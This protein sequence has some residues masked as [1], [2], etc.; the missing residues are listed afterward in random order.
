MIK[1]ILLTNEVYKMSIKLFAEND[2]IC[3][4]S[5]D[6]LMQYT[7]YF[8]DGHDGHDIGLVIILPLKQGKAINDFLASHD[9]FEFELDYSH[10]FGDVESLKRI[11]I[12]PNKVNNPDFYVLELKQAE[13]TGESYIESSTTTINEGSTIT[14]NNMSK[15]RK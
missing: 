4:V 12:E 5:H 6:G 13:T 1:N 8:Y 3:E 10:N 7:T 14:I 2:E 15:V 9:N 11:S